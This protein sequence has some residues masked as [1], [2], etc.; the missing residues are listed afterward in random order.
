MIKNLTRIDK[1]I[2]QY[3]LLLSQKM[4]KSMTKASE[5]K[6]LLKILIVL[7]NRIHHLRQVK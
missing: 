2:S 1:N 7:M 4:R 3:L 5:V 6:V